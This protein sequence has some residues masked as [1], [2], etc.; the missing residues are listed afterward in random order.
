MA[1]AIVVAAVVMLSRP[2]APTTQTGSGPN[3]AVSEP[4]ANSAIESRDAPS[5]AAARPDANPPVDQNPAGAAG[6]AGAVVP[7][8]ATRV[9]P[10]AGAAS[11]PTAPRSAAPEATPGN[12][13]PTRDVSAKQLFAGTGGS[14]AAATNAGLRYRLIRRSENGTEVDVDPAMTLDRKST[15]LNSS[16]IQKS[17]M[18]SS[19]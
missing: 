17:R 7:Q 3:T 10:S 4:A 18:P 9:A 12:A 16:H 2:S 1:A 8:V 5:N 6:A 11:A 15:R 19:A 14:A 13:E